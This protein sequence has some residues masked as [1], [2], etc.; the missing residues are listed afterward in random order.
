VFAIVFFRLLRVLFQ[1]ETDLWSNQSPLLNHSLS[2][3]TTTGN[4][5]FRNN[6]EIATKTVGFERTAVLN[7]GYRLDTHD[8]EAFP[9]ANIFATHRIVA[10]DHIA[11]R[12]GEA[13]PVAVIGSS[14]QLRLFSPYHPL[15]LILSLLPAVGTG[16]HMRTLFRSLIKKIALFH[17][18]PLRSAPGRSGRDGH[19]AILPDSTPL[20]QES[21]IITMGL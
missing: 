5:V 15:D 12:F 8:V 19:S 11:L 18:S 3:R 2:G 21:C 1:R 9:A 13:C 10:P 7:K 16:H 20:R 6:A 17:A 4:E 14:G